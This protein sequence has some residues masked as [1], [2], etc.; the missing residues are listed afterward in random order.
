MSENFRP[1]PGY[2]GLYEVGD[3]GNIKA[4]PR[5]VHRPNTRPYTTKERLL[6]PTV[7]NKYGHLHVSLTDENGVAK[8]HWVHRLVATV[9][10][11]RKPGDYLVRHG[12]NGSTDNRASELQWGTHSSN[13][14]DRIV[15]GTEPI[16]MPRTHCKRN[17]PLT[18][19]NVYS[20]PK[21]PND[22]HC[23]ACQRD[24]VREY[25]ERIA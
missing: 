22:R 4:L 6:K 1:A 24:R 5:V 18:G 23:K 25:R 7:G 12:P 17:H 3:L 13:A 9:W 16:Y 11:P 20:P 14:A 15:H 19:D 10:C 8:K 21:R 2:E